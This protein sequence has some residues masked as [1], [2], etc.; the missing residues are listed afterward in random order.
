MADLDGRQA[1]AHVLVVNDAEVL[2]RLRLSAAEAARVCGVT[3]R[4]LIYWTKKGLIRPSPDNDHDFDVFAM[5]KTIRI[6]KALEKGHS[7]EKAAQIA[8]GDMAALSAEVDRLSALPAAELEGE[9]RR[10]L[11]R[12]EDRL[13]GLRQVLPSSLGLARLRRAVAL[14]ARIEAQG[15]LAAASDG[16]GTK[17]FT[18]RLGRAVDE[19]ETLIREAPVTA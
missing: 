16:D 15:Q 19:L 8:E 4:Q 7:L 2:A 13:G 18:L 3:P 9:L 5:E 14:L 10:R 6:R 12:L 1:L 17:A 11:E